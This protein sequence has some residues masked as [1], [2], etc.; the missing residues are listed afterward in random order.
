ME[1]NIVWE[2]YPEILQKP[3][4]SERKLFN[5]QSEATI[6]TKGYHKDFC[7][8]QYF[9]PNFKKQNPDVI[10]NARYHVILPYEPFKHVWGDFHM[11]R[12]VHMALMDWNEHQFI[13]YWQD[14]AW[15]KSV[16]APVGKN[17]DLN[18][19]DSVGFFVNKN[20]A[21]DP[22]TMATTDFKK[23]MGVATM[24]LLDLCA[25]GTKKTTIQMLIQ[26]LGEKYDD[27]K[28]AEDHLQ[29]KKNPA[30]WE[31][32][33]NSVFQKAIGFVVMDL[34]EDKERQAAHVWK[35]TN[36][37]LQSFGYDV[38]KAASP[39][40]M[41]DLYKAGRKGHN[42]SA[43]AVDTAFN[44]AEPLSYQAHL[45]PKGLRSNFYAHFQ[46]RHKSNTIPDQEDGMC[47]KTHYLRFDEAQCKHNGNNTM[48]SAKEKKANE[49]VNEIQHQ[50]MYNWMEDHEAENKTLPE[51]YHEY[52]P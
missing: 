11:Y 10:F 49:A 19:L 48:F 21:P 13:K 26:N 39:K 3:P 20:A 51:H 29:A 42:G 36:L 44:F 17:K 37:F 22:S 15:K 30:Y 45:F 41:G 25:S 4:R 47:C 6:F 28:T 52:R 32:L 2:D 8:K 35:S 38:S 40:T 18:Y 33:D 16:Q 12:N 31:S 27:S 5:E 23:A 46:E 43:S 34:L 24:E 14:K 9:T 7:Y 50:A 1:Y